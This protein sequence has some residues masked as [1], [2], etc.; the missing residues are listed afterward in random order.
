LAEALRGAAALQQ[1]IARLGQA[2]MK[3]AG[4]GLRAEA[5]MIAKKAR[6]LCPVEA[7]VGRGAALRGS[8]EV[9][10]PEIKGKDISVAITA[11]GPSLDYATAVHEHPSE[12]S[13]SSWEGLGPDEIDWTV[14]GT[15][16]KFI[17]R[18]LLEAKDGMAERIGKRLDL[19]QAVK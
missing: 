4:A 10:K 7:K 18:P 3:V 6:R 15:G 14:P 17:E 19:A 12:H 13:P 9:H 11:G 1:K 5:E 2:G 16:P 8:I